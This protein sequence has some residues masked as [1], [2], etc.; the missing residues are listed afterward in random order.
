MSHSVCHHRT[1][2]CVSTFLPLLLTLYQILRKPEYF[3]RFGKV[4]KV[5]INK[6]KIYSGPQG[7]SVSCYITYSQPL[8]AQNAIKSIEGSTVDGRLLRASFGTT[9]YCTYFLRGIRCMLWIHELFRGHCRFTVLCSCHQL[10]SN[11]PCRS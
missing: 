5:V 6:D 2:F 9:K 1:Q 10:S 11:G 8:E 4:V 3:G 7:P